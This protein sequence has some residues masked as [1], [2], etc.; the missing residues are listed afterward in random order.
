M[1]VECE[2]GFGFDSTGSPTGSNRFWPPACGIRL[3]GSTGFSLG[4]IFVGF[5]QILVLAPCALDSLL[6]V[7]GGG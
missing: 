2:L 7:V 4:R 5:D 3:F 1:A 6:V